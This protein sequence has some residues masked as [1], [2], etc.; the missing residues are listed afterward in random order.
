MSEIAGPP[1]GL[2]GPELALST[3]VPWESLFSL[4]SLLSCPHLSL[5]NTLPP[6]TPAFC[7][8]T[9]STLLHGCPLAYP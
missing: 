5:P 6:L 3:T 2:T 7:P 1:R 9:C 4:L 8:L